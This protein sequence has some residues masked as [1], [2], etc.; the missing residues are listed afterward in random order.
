MRHAL[1]AGSLVAHLLLV[2]WMIWPE[3]LE[4]VRDVPAEM[5]LV[6]FSPPPRCADAVWIEHHDGCIGT[7]QLV[8]RSS[9]RR[10]LGAS[11]RAAR[12]VVHVQRE[13]DHAARDTA[14]R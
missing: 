10:T 8:C 5:V 11:V 1:I 12:R 3:R 9:I 7:R 6:D 2:A 13:R 14:P 4:Q